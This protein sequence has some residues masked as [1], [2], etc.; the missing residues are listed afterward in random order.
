M[1]Y[2]PQQLWSSFLEN[3][4]VILLFV[5]VPKHWIF[6]LRWVV[7]GISRTIHVLRRWNE[8]AAYVLRGW[9]RVSWLE[10]RL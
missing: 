2:L 4:R 6:G 1:K 9:H 7:N 8:L 5:D 3:L 10:C